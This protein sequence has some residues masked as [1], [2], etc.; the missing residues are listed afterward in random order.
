MKYSNKTLQQLVF[1]VYKIHLEMELLMLLPSAE[2]QV[3]KSLCALVKTSKQPL[4]FL[5]MQELSH[6]R[7]QK[8]QMHSMP[9]LQVKNLDKKLVSNWLRILMILQERK[10]S[11]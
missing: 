7:R 9:A 10:L 6:Q 5:R 3:S 4:L 1:G 11:V 2:L 8:V